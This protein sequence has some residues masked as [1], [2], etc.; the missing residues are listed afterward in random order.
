MDVIK[1]INE[2]CKNQL[3]GSLAPCFIIVLKDTIHFYNFP[4]I[5]IFT[6]FIFHLNLSPTGCPRKN[7]RLQE[8]DLAYKRTF[9]LGH[10]V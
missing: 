3:I 1:S 6:T 9:F 10:L 5:L 4:S 8:G 2:T 7:V